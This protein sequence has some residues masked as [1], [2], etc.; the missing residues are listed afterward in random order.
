[1]AW[2]I[3]KTGPLVVPYV[4]GL[5][6]LFTLAGC[7]AR[8]GLDDEPVGAP[9]ADGGALPCLT[10]VAR[11]DLR[12]CE[13]TVTMS[14]IT[15]DRPACWTDTPIAGSTGAF[16]VP[17]DGGAVNVMLDEIEFSGELS[18]DC[19]LRMVAHTTFPWSDGCQWESTQVISGSLQPRRLDYEYRELPVAGEVDCLEPCSAVSSLVV[20]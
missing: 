14:G 19:H 5:I 20:E 8:T 16:S 4:T 17:C 6:S 3:P 13:I 11:C 1:M 12:E 7:G 15:E 18:P 2:G 9:C 10:G